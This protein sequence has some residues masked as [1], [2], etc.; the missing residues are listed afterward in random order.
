MKD[1]ATI[2]DV[3]EASDGQ[4]NDILRLIMAHQE[5]ERSMV[6]GWKDAWLTEARAQVAAIEHGVSHALARCERGGTTRQYEECL[7]DVQ[8][9]LFNGL[10]DGPILRWYI[11]QE[12]ANPM[13]PDLPVHPRYQHCGDFA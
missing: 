4:A 13:Q 12:K 3:V 2:I 5:A 10:C 1:E 11:E 8:L 9:A 6:D 7:K